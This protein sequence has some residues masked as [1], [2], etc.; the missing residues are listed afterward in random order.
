MD[1]QVVLTWQRFGRMIEACKA[2]KE[3]SCLYVIAEPSGKPLYI[4]GAGGRD[5]LDGRYR[6]GTASA[7]DAALHGSA[8]II[9]VAPIPDDKVKAA[10]KALIFA[11][12]PMYNRQGKIVPLTAMPVESLVHAGDPPQFTYRH[13]IR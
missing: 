4:G 1:G 10:E 6:G 8:N 5:G 13:R 12:K 11:E 3:R 7:V 9:F 2:F